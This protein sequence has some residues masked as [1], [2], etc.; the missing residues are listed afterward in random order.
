MSRHGRLQRERVPFLSDR[1]IE[2]HADLLLAEWANTEA[3]VSVPV[4]LDD[5]V[6]LHLGLTY[7]VDD[8]RSMFGRPDV[9]GAIWFDCNLIRI[10]A[11]LDPSTNPAMLGRYNFTLAHEIGHW[12][13]H[14]EH[15]RQDPDSARL[16]EAN[17]EPAFVC[18]SSLKPR[19]EWQADHF[20]GCVLMPRTLL[21]QEWVKWR[22]S[23][24]PVASEDL[25][26]SSSEDDRELAENR[27]LEDL[28]RPLAR[29][30]HVSAQAMRIRL[31]SIGLFVSRIE[32]TLFS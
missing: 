27:V 15:L 21:M 29:E 4:P 20:A 22:G 26:N 1:V 6:E 2:E 10:D 32:P 23:P 7:E 28:C 9:L 19:E 12:R 13:L 16:F 11:T 8:L 30:F 17:A 31:Q 24:D 3:P 25:L 14:R 5:I 18:R